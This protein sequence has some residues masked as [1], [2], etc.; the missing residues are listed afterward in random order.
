[1]HAY[2]PLA[3]T[4]LAHARPT[5]APTHEPTQDIIGVTQHAMRA[6]MARATRRASRG[7]EMCARHRGA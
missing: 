4:S 7:D 1:M 3:G 2:V 6:D 5:R